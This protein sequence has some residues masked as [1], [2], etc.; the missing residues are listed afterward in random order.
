MSTVQLGKKAKL[1]VS[2]TSDGAKTDIT[3]VAVGA[4]NLTRA[5][6]ST[7]RQVPGGRGVLASQLGRFDTH[8]FATSHDSNP[9][10]D[11]LFRDGNQRRLWCEFDPEGVGS[12]LPR[13]TFQA[14]VTPVWTASLENDACTWAVTW[15]VDGAPVETVQ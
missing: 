3:G 6:A 2:R 1:R 13:L 7:V 10:H 5:I 15:M 11:P 9:A 4:G 14:V 12:G 8:D